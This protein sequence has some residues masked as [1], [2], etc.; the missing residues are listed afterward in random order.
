MADDNK[1]WVGFDLGGTK[2]YSCLFDK[3]MKMVVSKR[4]KTKG[5]LEAP[6][7]LERIESSIRKMMEEVQI[8]PALIAGIG[9]GCP[10]PV[11]WNT[12]VVRLAV[13]LGWKDVPVGKFLEEKFKCPV[14]VLND[15]DAGVYGEYC[16]GAAKGSRSTVGIF[17]GTGI[18]GGCVYEGKILRGKS[19]TCMEVGHIKITS[20]SNTNPTTM[21]GTLEAVASR[22]AISAE[23]AKLAFRGEA[24]SIL[25]VA[26]TDVAQIRSKVIAEAVEKG[27]KEVVA[28]VRKA[29]TSIGHAVANLVHLICPDCIVL[30]GGLIEAMPDLFLQEVSKTAKKSVLPCYA[31]EFQVVCAKLGDD[32]GAMGAAGWIA[33][34]VSGTSN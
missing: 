17:P 28:V 4:K 15:V 9:I 26:G 19:L 18:G 2:M 1:Y 5:E 6:Q 20:S 30:G 10:G 8:D 14:A 3:S 21:E 32:A 22:L 13:N 29:A 16:F 7:N 23:L 27:E 34:Q 25:K 11:E 31:D 24:P 12:G 33:Q